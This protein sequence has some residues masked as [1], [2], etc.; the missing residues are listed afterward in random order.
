ME[1]V[2][3]LCILANSIWVFI[4]VMYIIWTKGK[5]ISRVEQNEKYMN[6]FQI[7]PIKVIYN[8]PWKVIQKNCWEITTI[9]E[10]SGDKNPRYKLVNIGKVMGPGDWRI[11][12]WKALAGSNA[13]KNT[14]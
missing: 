6:E 2:H 11:S 10:V 1:T 14:Y 3:V 4:Y 9:E 8:K 5:H 7:Q 13:L 12:G